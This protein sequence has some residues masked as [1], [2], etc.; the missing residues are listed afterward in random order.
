MQQ[1][2]Q[3]SQTLQSCGRVFLTL[4]GLPFVLFLK[5]HLGRRRFRNS[6]VAV[7]VR[8]WLRMQQP[9]F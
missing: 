7:A 3:V 4:P 9:D 1:T 8:E 2:G 5:Q 6:E